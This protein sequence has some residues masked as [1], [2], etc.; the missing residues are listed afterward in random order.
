MK[1]LTKKAKL[2]S[3]D[4]QIREF[5]WPTTIRTEILSEIL[6]K[7][8]NGITVYKG[9]LLYPGIGAFAYKRGTFLISNFTN[10]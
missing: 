4:G 6:H 3:L 5:I 2:G 7:N 1:K 9:R 10:R 8:F